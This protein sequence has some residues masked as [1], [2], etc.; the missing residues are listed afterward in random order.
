MKKLLGGLMA[1]LAL[2]RGADLAAEC[3]EQFLCEK[4]S[5]E[6]FRAEALILASDRDPAD[7]V[8]RRTAAL[9]ADLQH[10]SP[11]P[12]LAKLGRQFDALQKNAELIA[13][14]D[15]LAR[16]TLFDQACQL[17]RQIAF[18]NPLLDF[19][20]LLFVKRHRGIYNHMCDQF[21]GI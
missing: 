7:V 3:D 11:T 6:T 19:D 15:A 18:A 5:N 8:L 21:Y 13:P 2:A 20:Q 9:L 14:S 1:V 12:K 10:N 16:R 17:R 4:L